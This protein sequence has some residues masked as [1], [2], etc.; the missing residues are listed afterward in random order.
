[1]DCEQLLTKLYQTAPELQIAVEQKMKNGHVQMKDGAV[2][3]WL[4][5]VMGC[6]MPM[7]EHASKNAG[8]L[9]AVFS[10]ME[11]I[12]QADTGTKELLL[13]SFNCFLNEEQVIPEALS[14]MG[15]ETRK[16]WDEYF[17]DLNQ[18]QLWK[19]SQM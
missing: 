4:I 6:V 2:I 10:V 12:A 14:R 19:L 1:M 5:G 15:P 11:W 18:F 16:F 17:D 8:S 3:V 7:M 13:V 9:D